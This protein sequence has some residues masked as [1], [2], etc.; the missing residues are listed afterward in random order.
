MKTF[1]VTTTSIS[2]QDLKDL[3]DAFSLFDKDGDGSITPEELGVVMRRLG[4]APS[5]EELENMLN[6]IDIDANGTID[7]EEFATMMADKMNHMDY[8]DEM[9]QVSIQ[10][11]TEEVCSGYDIL[12]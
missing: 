12:I 1:P 11:T 4:H 2:E 7:F 3:R 10:I 8:D 5:D 6:V 9:K